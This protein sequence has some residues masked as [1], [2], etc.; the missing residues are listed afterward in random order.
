MSERGRSKRPEGPG[1]LAKA[2]TA[3]F[4]VL[5]IPVRIMCKTKIGG[6]KLT[7]EGGFRSSSEES[8][9]S[10]ADLGALGESQKRLAIAAKKHTELLPCLSSGK[11]S[12]SFQ[13]G[14]SCSG[15]GRCP[16]GRWW[17]A[18]A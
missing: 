3:E 4:D 2:R 11:R 6:K 18:P 12:S 5:R 10:D 15:E 7:L 16:S 13:W 9:T 17:G 14:R 8:T 1:E